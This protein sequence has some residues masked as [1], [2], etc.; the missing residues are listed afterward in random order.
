MRRLENPSK[1]LDRASDATI[2]ALYFSAQSGRIFENQTADGEMKIPAS[3]KELAGSCQVWQAVGDPG[4]PR[5][6]NKD[7]RTMR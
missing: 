6:K 2:R 7:R 1:K 4:P 5:A 3:P